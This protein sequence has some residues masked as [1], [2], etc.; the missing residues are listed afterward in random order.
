MDIDYH[1]GTMYVLSRWAKFRSANA[2]IIA[3]SCQLVD[4]NYDDNPFSDQYENSN[5][6]DGIKIRYS[7]QNIVGNVTGKGNAEVWV[8]FHFLPGLQGNTDAERLIC[9]KN[10]KLAIALKNRLLKTTLDNARFGF[11]LGVGLHVYADTWAH[12]EFAGINNTINKVQ[13]L[14]FSTQGSLVQKV[15]AD[16]AGSA[17]IF[18][19]N[20]FMTK[21]LPLGHAAAVHCPDMPF[22]WWKCNERFANGRKNWDEFMEA[23]ESIFRILQSVS[24]EPVT[25]L[26]DEQQKLLYRCFKGIQYEDFHQRMEIWLKRIHSNFFQFEDFCQE[27]TQVEYSPGTIMNDSDWKKKFYDEINDHF[28]W[29]LDQLEEN[30]LFILKSEPI[31]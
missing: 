28:D 2:N 21:A 8:P 12:Q 1:Y 29:V 22:L 20:K 31:Y 23:S 3:T 11:R 30:D 4:D 27:D 10:S 7:K 19:I 9:K 26:S 5:V 17:S 14:I 15:L 13:N 6:A 25:G 24:C 18:S 16:I